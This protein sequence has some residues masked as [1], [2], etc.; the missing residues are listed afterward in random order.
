MRLRLNE[1]IKVTHN[2]LELRFK[3]KIYDYKSKILLKN[4]NTFVITHD[5]PLSSK[6][7]P[8][9]YTL[10]SQA[11]FI[12]Y[13]ILFIFVLTLG[14]ATY[15]THAIFSMWADSYTHANHSGPD[16]FKQQ[17]SIQYLPPITTGS[18]SQY[19]QYPINL[20]E[21]QT[22]N[23]QNCSLAYFEGCCAFTNQDTSPLNQQP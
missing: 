17:P 20:K 2:K 1:L 19:R 3:C 14:L 10:L 12:S 7:Q 4:I 6:S 23:G 13:A 22:E 8:N 21:L 9:F 18:V 5:Y 15:E 16:V 11:F